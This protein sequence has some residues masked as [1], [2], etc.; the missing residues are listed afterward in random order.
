[1]FLPEQTQFA[2]G[3]SPFGPTQL[4]NNPLTRELFENGVF[5]GE[6]SSIMTLGAKSFSL[7]EIDESGKLYDTYIRIVGEERKKL[8]I[9]TINDDA[10]ADDKREYGTGPNSVPSVE[11]RKAIAVG[12]RAGTERFLEELKNVLIKDPKLATPIAIKL[13][14]EPEELIDYLTDNPGSKLLKGPVKFSPNR[15]LLE[16]PIPEMK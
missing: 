11:L 14:M 10:Y 2:S 5:P 13:A 7:L 12:K 4:K 6:P 9:E 16:Y 15:E 8:V 3:A 1:M